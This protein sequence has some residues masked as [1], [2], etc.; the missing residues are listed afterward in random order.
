MK[1]VSTRTLRTI[2]LALFVIMIGLD[3]Y[4]MWRIAFVR[5]EAD[6]PA[7]LA[8]AHG[9]LNGTNP[10]IPTTVA[11]YNNPPYNNP[12]TFRP[13]IYPLFIAWLWIPFAL[14][15]PIVASFVWFLISVGVLIL[16]L[17]SLAQ[18]FGIKD[19][20][21]QLLFYG[22]LTILFVSII[23]AELMYGQMNLFVLFLLLLGV[24]YLEKNPIASGIGFGAAISAKFMPI[25]LLPVII[26]RNLRVSILTILAIL[27]LA[28]GIPF[29]IAG[30]N[31]FDY[32]HYWFNSTIAGEITQG[33]HGYAS[34]DVASVLAQLAGMDYPTA[35]MRMICG[36]GL[37]TFPIILMRKKSDLAGFCLAFM[38]LPLT[39]SRS[40]PAHLIILM[41]A[42]GL[43]LANLIK[44]NSKL[45]MWIGLLALQL[46]ILWGFNKAIPFDTVGML[47][48]FGVVFMKGI[49][50]RRLEIA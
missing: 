17:R 13:F 31:I 23:Q 42:M 16:I 36:L 44:N 15:P 32:Y 12:D 8:G 27:V 47:V 40:E 45:W 37:L 49:G 6:F 22:S 20:R 38:L 10:Y 46:M 19:E 14:L 39:A 18:L 24:K 26:L 1:P 21:Q 29:L 34:F 35:V 50:P 43:L 9:L 11:P 3:A 2:L 25:V 30:T 5:H 7:Y 28:V 48:L 33:N 4:Q 41:P